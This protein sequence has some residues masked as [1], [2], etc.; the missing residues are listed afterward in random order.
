M[1]ESYRIT[2]SGSFSCPSNGIVEVVTID[3]YMQN[4]TAVLY[5]GTDDTGKR[6]CTL[7]TIAND[8]KTTP[9]LNI[10]YSGGLYG[11][12]AGTGAGLSVIVR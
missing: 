1:S 4:S 3:A 2:V 11:S 6:I 7:A 8:S 5:S 12:I 9:V 10:P